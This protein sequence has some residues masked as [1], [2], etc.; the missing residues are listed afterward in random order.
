MS[1]QLEFLFLLLRV[2][3]SS[4]LRRSEGY[5]FPLFQTKF[6]VTAEKIPVPRNIFP[7]NFRKELSEKW[8]QHSG[9][10]L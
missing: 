1:E 10:L 7:V 3:S 6:P 9:F 4:I 2:Y 5:N 8:L